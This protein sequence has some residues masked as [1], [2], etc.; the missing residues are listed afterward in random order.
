[1]KVGRE[2]HDTAEATTAVVDAGRRCIV[3]AADMIPR[4]EAVSPVGAGQILAWRIPQF[5]FSRTPLPEVVALL[6][7]HAADHGG[8]R[9]E[10]S[11][12]ELNQIKLTG[13]LRADNTEGLVRLLETSFEVRAKRTGERISLQK[14]RP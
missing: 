12:A 5:E 11:D 1:V 8:T 2:S 3:D 14:K 7:H 13:F 4:V 9:L 10:I 6:N